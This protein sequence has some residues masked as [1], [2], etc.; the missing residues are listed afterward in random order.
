MS[1]LKTATATTTTT[2]RIPIVALS[3]QQ[4]LLS[5]KSKSSLQNNLV[6]ERAIQLTNNNNSNINH[7]LYLQYINILGNPTI[8]EKYLSGTVRLKPVE[9]KPKERIFRE[10]THLGDQLIRLQ[11]SYTKTR[12]H[13]QYVNS[14]SSS[15]SNVSYCNKKFKK[16]ILSFG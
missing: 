8:V 11:V 6:R 10:V 3:N 12:I 7:G 16:L 14:S 13:H 5:T 2:S 15:S 1:D 9:R 4:H